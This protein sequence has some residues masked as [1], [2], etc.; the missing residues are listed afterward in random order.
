MLHE[1]TDPKQV[2]QFKEHVEIPHAEQGTTVICPVVP[3]QPPSCHGQDRCSSLTPNVFPSLD[4]AGRPGCRSQARLCPLAPDLHP[5]G[6]TSAAGLSAR[7]GFP[8]PFCCGAG[9]CQ[10][11]LCLPAKAAAFQPHLQPGGEVS[12][13]ACHLQKQCLRLGEIPQTQ[14][15][16]LVPPPASGQSLFKRSKPGR[17]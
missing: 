10:S 13:A 9:S 12:C 16:L 11:S 2:C 4:H 17:P 6:P 7:W 8:N 14:P 5:S 1:T 3:A 15:V